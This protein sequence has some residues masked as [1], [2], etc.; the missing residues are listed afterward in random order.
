MVLQS[1]PGRDWSGNVGQKCNDSKWECFATKDS[2]F[3]MGEPGEVWWERRKDE[4]ER[5]GD[6]QVAMRV[7]VQMRNG[8]N[9]STL[10]KLAKIGLGRGG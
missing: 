6:S 3:A 5:G 2:S 4:G 9:N 7:W 8:E 1:L 10:R